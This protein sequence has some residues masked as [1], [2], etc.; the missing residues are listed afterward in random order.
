MSSSP[1]PSSN[2][3]LATFNHRETS[4]C[5]GALWFTKCNSSES[6]RGLHIFPGGFMHKKCR[7][8]AW[9]TVVQRF[10]VAK[11][12]TKTLLRTELE[13]FAVTKR[14]GPE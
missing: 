4:V 1:C 12:N 7:T 10:Q 5:F 2:R 6:W 13:W 14:A 8:V 9:E 3:M 11:R